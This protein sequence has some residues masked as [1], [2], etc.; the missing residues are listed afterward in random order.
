MS[1]VSL[2]AS[3]Q[4]ERCGDRDRS[5]VPVGTG[6]LACSECCN[7]LK[8]KNLKAKGDVDAVLL[9]QI[10]NFA[11]SKVKT[12]IDGEL[13][14]GL[15][16]EGTYHAG[17]EFAATEHRQVLATYRYG[18]YYFHF[19]GIPTMLEVVTVNEVGFDVMA[20][21]DFD[22]DL[23]VQ[24]TYGPQ[25][26][27]K[28][29]KDEG[30]KPMA[31]GA[32]PDLE[33]KGDGVEPADS[34]TVAL[35]LFLQMTPILMFNHVARP[36]FQFKLSLNSILRLDASSS[37]CADLEELVE[38]G[39]FGSFDVA[40]GFGKVD[41]TTTKGKQ[42]SNDGVTFL[43]SRS[44][45]LAK[46]RIPITGRVPLSC[47]GASPSASSA[48]MS[49]RGLEGA[50]ECQDFISDCA[51]AIQRG[52]S[53][54]DDFCGTCDY[55]GLC[56][57]ACTF[58]D[59]TDEGDDTVTSLDDGG[60]D[61][62]TCR[63]VSGDCHLAVTRWGYLC[64]Q[65][66]CESCGVYASWC[67]RTC[68]YC[69]VD[70]DGGDEGCNN[71]CF[72]ARNGECDDGQPNSTYDVCACGSDCEDCGARTSCTS[73]SASTD[74][75]TRVDTCANSCPWASDGECDDG[76]PGSEYNVCACGTDCADCGN[77]ECP[78]E[79]TDA[80]PATCGG[81][82]CDFWVEH[83][84]KSC[85]D[86]ENEYDCNCDGCVECE[87]QNETAACAPLSC[88]E[89]SCDYWVGRGYT[90][91]DLESLGC[92]CNNCVCDTTAGCLNTCSY[93]SDGECDENRKMVQPARRFYPSSG[94][95]QLLRY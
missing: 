80:C 69:A 78:A 17:T 47:Q 19:A 55:S 70:D 56:D 66:F 12:Y 36:S 16:V 41:T 28:Y 83:Y 53:C 61:A 67:D 72:Y 50:D 5:F 20:T 92:D 7:D 51:A 38:L 3:R 77:R 87:G 40:V 33:L 95:S 60:S 76:E 62:G 37:P 35:G 54:D 11:I 34:G 82:S 71:L 15:G 73:T 89:S 48:R 91:S 49:T 58:C 75:R 27:F 4:G 25:V 31:G 21:V 68:G 10:E 13:E 81:E 86:L 24:G 42:T 90:C 22:V 29:V 43:E 23:E 85:A 57:A 45:P 94:P 44:M 26:G 39:V 30:F 1:K 8:Y 79:N 59:A 6:A 2:S 52:W 88:F 18:P 32:F 84:G 46:L 65:D 63:D 9:F 14:L 74:G 64:A 93:S